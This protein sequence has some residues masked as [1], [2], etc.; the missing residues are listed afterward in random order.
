MDAAGTVPIL[1][2]DD[3]VLVVAKPPGLLV[4][5]GGDAR[6]AHLVQILTPQW[7][8]LWVVHRL[9]RAVSGAVMLAR[10]P[11]ARKVLARA[12]AQGRAG[13]IYHAL[14]R[15]NPAWARRELTWPL[16]VNVGRRKRS[17]VD[18]RRGRPATTAVRVLRRFGSH[19]LVEAR[20]HPALRHQVRVHLFAAGHPIAGD[21]LYGPGPLPEDPLPRLALHA[22]RAFWVHPTT[23]AELQ[24]TAL[25]TA[26]WEA[27]LEALRWEQALVDREEEA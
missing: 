10:T 7:G 1:H 21:P 23:G 6:F 2:A 20:P 27:A 19:T 4:A 24:V 11:A 15:G 17:V 25:Y 18:P 12:W 16:R 14:V 26:D 5:P 8:P 3:Q 9:E 13:L 22:R